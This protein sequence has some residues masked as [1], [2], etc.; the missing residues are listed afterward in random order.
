M[1]RQVDWKKII[2]RHISDKGLTSRTHK[3]PSKVNNKKTMQLKIGLVFEQTGH[4]KWYMGGKYEKI[5][6]L[7]TREKLKLKP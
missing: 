4:Q 3:E 6:N 5:L 2:A 7:L 1:K